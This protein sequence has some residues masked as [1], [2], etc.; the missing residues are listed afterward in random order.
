MKENFKLINGRYQLLERVGSGSSGLVYKAVDLKKESKVVALKIL[1]PVNL[2]DLMAR[3]R[4]AREARIT[5]RIKHPNV[6]KTYGVGKAENDNHF[7]VMEFVEGQPLGKHIYSDLSQ[8]SFKQ[9]L[10]ILRDIALGVGYAHSQ[11]IVH[12]DLK[13][14]N[15]LVCPNGLAKVADFGLARNLVLDQSITATNETVGTWFYMAPEQFQNHIIDERADIYSLG[16]I[17]YEMVMQS[18]PFYSDTY[19]GIFA[20]HL[21]KPI[22]DLYSTRF[23]IPRWFETFVGVCAEKKPINRYQSMEDVV[24]ELEKRMDMHF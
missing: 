5:R 6:V 8:L 9:I 17:A 23:S 13:P 20:Q 1:S 10:L 3:R 16:I 18:R 11:G 24:F 22:P 7:L 19:Q 4:F 12:R 15:V 21:M 14:A 2:S